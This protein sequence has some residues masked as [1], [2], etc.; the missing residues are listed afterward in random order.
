[1]IELG[2]ALPDAMSVVQPVNPSA[3]GIVQGGAVFDAVRP[4]LCGLYPLRLDLDPVIAAKL[5]LQVIEAEQHLK[6]VRGGL[7]NLD[8]GLSG[9]SA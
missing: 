1:M 4:T 8:S 2:S 9:F 3:L 7:G 5:K 6:F